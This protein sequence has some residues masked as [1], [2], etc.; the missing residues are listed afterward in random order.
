MRI[1]PEDL[2]T[3]EERHQPAIPA[4]EVDVPLLLYAVGQSRDGKRTRPQRGG[5][6]PARRVPPVLPVEQ[7]ER[8]CR[9]VGPVQVRMC[10][11]PL[12]NVAVEAQRWC[13][14][15]RRGSRP[16]WTPVTRSCVMASV[17]G[18]AT[19]LVLC[20]ARASNEAVERP[21]PRVRELRVLTQHSST[22]GVTGQERSLVGT[23]HCGL[24]RVRPHHT[25]LPRGLGDTRQACGALGA[26][27]TLSV[28]LVEVAA[29]DPHPGVTIRSC[30]HGTALTH[31][32]VPVTARL[33]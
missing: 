13:R 9:H 1:G 25:S 24:V 2:R 19:R 10:R 28:D 7:A 5:I 17:S 32:T 29:L 11:Y 6:Q 16:G 31:H 20:A 18:V 26:V 4:R 30:T 27:P 14:I 22:D 8:R 21:P 23:P 15:R 12:L 3:C 33:E